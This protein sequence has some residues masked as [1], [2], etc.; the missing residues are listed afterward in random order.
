MIEVAM[1]TGS[2]DA[3]QIAATNLSWESAIQCLRASTSRHETAFFQAQPVWLAV[4]LN[5]LQ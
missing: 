5:Q 2:S 3:T 1:D 4:F